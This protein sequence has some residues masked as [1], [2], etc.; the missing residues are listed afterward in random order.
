MQIYNTI[1]GGGYF[2]EHCERTSKM[3]TRCLVW[4]TY[5]NDVRN[6][7]THFKYQNVTSR[8]KEINFNFNLTLHIHIKDKFQKHTINI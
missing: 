7:G 1:T 2:V 6:A 3:E 8:L 4:M 5:L